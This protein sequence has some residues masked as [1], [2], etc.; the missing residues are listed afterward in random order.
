LLTV[1]QR[2]TY[3]PNH[4][5]KLG[6]A[7]ALLVHV[8][9]SGGI[10]IAAVGGSNLYKDSSSPS[11]LSTDHAL[12][13]AGYLI[14]LL[15]VVLLA[16][17]A[18]QTLTGLRRSSRRCA[19]LTMTHW[20]LAAIPFVFVRVIYSVVYAFDNKPSLSPVTGSFAVKFVLIFLVQVVAACC[21][22]VGGFQTRAIATQQSDVETC[23]HHFTTRDEMRR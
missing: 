14:L 21:L 11:K 16:M 23:G 19:A 3:A 1:A 15:A 5:V 6:W 8:F 22:V 2:S 12:Q 13:K 9:V 17:R 4:N 10:A 20:V 18:A 7:F